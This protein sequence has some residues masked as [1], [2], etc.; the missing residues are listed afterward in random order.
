MQSKRLSNGRAIRIA[1]ATLAIAVLVLLPRSTQAQAAVN[2]QGGGRHIYLPMVKGGPAPAPTAK[3][4]LPPIPTAQPTSPPSGGQVFYVAPTGNDANPGTQT[5]PWRTLAKANASLRAGQT[6]YVRAGTYAEQVKPTASGTAS[7][8]ITF[9]AYPGETVVLDGSRFTVPNWSGLVDVSGRSYLAVKG[10][11]AQNSGYAG[12]FASG[13]H[14][15]L[16]QGNHTLHSYTSGI[17]VWSSTNIVVDGNDVENSNYGGGN[18]ALSVGGTGFFEIKHN[19]VH[20]PAAT[21]SQP[22]KEGIDVKQGSHDGSVHHNEIYDLQK[23]ALYA[24]AYDQHTYNL[25]YYANRIHDV[26]MGITLASEAGGLLENVQVYNN[27]IWNVYYAGIRTFGQVET[28]SHP[29]KD[30]AYLN[31]TVYNAG[32]GINVSNSQITNF[33]VRNNLAPSYDLSASGVVQD[34]NLTSANPGYANPAAGDF[35]LT[36][37]SAAIDK[38]SATGAPATDYAGTPRPQGAAVDIGAYESR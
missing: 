33:V 23:V 27:L 7:A 25:H 19:T 22:L 13:A 38:G 8:W 9:A 32:G 28:A 6:V 20:N 14:H 36:A 24:D 37:G 34:H 30:I 11:T 21:S 35:R 10:F 3:P 26:R 29:M 18:E 1:C 15:I 16:F 12:L 17:G 31:N 2:A 4:A 5:A